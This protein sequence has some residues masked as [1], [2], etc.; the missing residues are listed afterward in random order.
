MFLSDQQVMTG[1][2]KC[3]MTSLDLA[4]ATVFLSLYVFLA[5]LCILLFTFFQPSVAKRGIERNLSN[6]LAIY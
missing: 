5:S 3:L 1:D 2:D 6:S 4:G